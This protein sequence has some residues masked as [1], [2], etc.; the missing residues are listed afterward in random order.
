MRK[1]LFLI[2]FFSSFLYSEDKVIPQWLNG[3][4]HIHS[5]YSKGI[6]GTG[7]GDGTPYQLTERALNPDPLHPNFQLREN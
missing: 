7:P 6:L 2:L 5:T 4:I 3:D 1:T